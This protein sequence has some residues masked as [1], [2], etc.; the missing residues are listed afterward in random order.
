[1]PGSP[2]KIVVPS[3]IGDFSWIY[4]KFSNLSVML[5]VSIADMGPPRL[6]PLTQILPKVCDVHH[7]R[8]GFPELRKRAVRT[9]VTLNELDQMRRAGELVYVESNSHLEAGIRIERWV[10]QLPVNHHY[11]I[12]IDKEYV[13]KALSVVPKEPF[14]VIFAAAMATAKAWNAWM[15]QQWV[16]FMCLFRK[17]FGDLAFVIIGAAWDAPMGQQIHQLSVQN[18][19]KVTNLVSQTHIA[20]SIHIISLSKYFVAF[21]SGMGILSDVICAPAT[22]FYPQALPKMPGSYADPESTKSLRFHERFFCP[23]ADLIAWLRD[24]YKIKEKL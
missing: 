15:P 14:V 9:E 17:E 23:P 12:R 6:E 22:M 10:P 1:M 3:G 11:E 19:L 13:D 18:H 7:L 21:P 16:E 8:M 5:E 4:S 24:V 2:L 20:A